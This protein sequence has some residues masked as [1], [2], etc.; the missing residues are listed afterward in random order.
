MATKKLTY[1]EAMAE[2]DKILARLRSGQVGVDELSHDVARATKLI[3]ECRKILC[4]TETEVERLINP[5]N[6]E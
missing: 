2:V 5:K 3:E 1:A 6:E 4:R